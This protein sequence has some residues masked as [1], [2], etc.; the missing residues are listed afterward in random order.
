M[1]SLSSQRITLT[2]F[3]LYNDTRENELLFHNYYFL[4]SRFA[5]IKLINLV[6]EFFFLLKMGKI[7]ALWLL[8]SIFVSINVLRIQ[9]TDPFLKRAGSYFTLDDFADIEEPK[10]KPDQQMSIFRLPPH[11]KPIKYDLKITPNLS[12]KFDF[13]GSVKIIIKAISSTR[14]VYLHSKNLQI[15]EFKVAKNGRKLDAGIKIDAVNEIIV[16]QLDEELVPPDTYEMYFNFSGILNDDMR[17]FY[18]SSYT[19][20]GQTK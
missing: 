15:K 12:G 6:C 1:S 17:G 2:F 18:R 19:V 20:D 10:L 16:V 3:F 7:Q 13:W 4:I 14:T 9:C 5:R 11:T 8:L